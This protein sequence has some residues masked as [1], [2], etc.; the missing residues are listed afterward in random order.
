MLSWY[1]VLGI[2]S[3]AGA[4]EIRAAYRDQARALHPD[5]R[6]PALPAAE[7][8]AA[9]RLVNEAWSVLGDPQR[10]AAY[11]EWLQVGAPADTGPEAAQFHAAPRF[12]WWAVAL[13]VLLVIFVFTA[14]AG[15]PAD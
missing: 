10:R 8:D 12:P 14:Y 3:D 4:A 11:D 7:A 5:S 6:D 13:V 2:D 15:G 1:E 9:L